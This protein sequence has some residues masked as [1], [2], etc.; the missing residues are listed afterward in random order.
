MSQ[1]TGNRSQEAEKDGFTGKTADKHPLSPDTWNLSP[2]IYAPDC[3]WE[4]RCPGFE[5]NGCGGEGFGW[6]IKDKIFGV[7]LHE[8]CEIHDICYDFLAARQK[9]SVRTE[10]DNEWIW[11]DDRADADE[12]L[13]HN[14]RVLAADNGASGWT[15]RN[16]VA[17]VM[18][19]ATF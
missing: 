3:W 8:A 16:I 2:E 11:I 18:W 4:A 13:N 15:V 5:T 10:N 1:E 12:L 14:I 7:D 17:P 9:F 6:L 19:G